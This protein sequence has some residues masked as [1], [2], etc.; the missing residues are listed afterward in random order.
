MMRHTKYQVKTLGLVVLDKKI[1]SCF[2]YISLCK[3]S[4]PWGGAIL[5][6]LG[7]GPLGNATYQISRL[8]AL[9]FQT[10][11]IFHV[12]LYK[13]IILTYDPQGRAILDPRDII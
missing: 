12:S 13:P 6:I 2:P 1:F 11:R 4:D 8:W 7:R 9:R 3:T 10:R 5:N